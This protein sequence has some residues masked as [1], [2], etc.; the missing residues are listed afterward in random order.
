LK[1]GKIKIDYVK[2]NIALVSSERRRYIPIGLMTPEIIAS[3]QL[4]IVPAPQIY[5]FGILMS[6]IHMAWMRAVAGRLKSDYRYS[7]SVVYNNFAWC[8]PRTK[9]TTALLLKLTTL[10]IFWTMNQKS[11]QSCLK[12]TSVNRAD[13]SR[14]KH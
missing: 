3:S 9:K 12:C 8:E 14:Q 7:G 5:H 13:R 11:S 2:F 10:K 6:S 1:C 4:I